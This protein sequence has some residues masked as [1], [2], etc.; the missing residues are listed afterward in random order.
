VGGG[1]AGGIGGGLVGMIN[2]E[3]HSGIKAIMSLTSFEAKVKCADLIITGEGT[4]DAQ[5]MEGKV[6]SGVADLAKR[7]KKNL[8][9]LTGKDQLSINK[10][11]SLNAQFLGEIVNLSK[12]TEDAMI[13]GGM[14]LEKLGY[15]AI[16]NYFK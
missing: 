1:A 11:N 15:E 2:A 14:Y 9:I 16:E 13:N 6:V 4:L 5:S 12:D 10:M 3:I 7:Y 8:Y